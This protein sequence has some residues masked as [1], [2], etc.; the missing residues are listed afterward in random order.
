M[1]TFSPLPGKRLPVGPGSRM[2]SP[3]PRFGGV[4]PEPPDLQPDSPVSG[5][6][7]APDLSV[8]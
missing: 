5:T 6:L 2:G 8:S 1:A 3:A 7:P 4:Q